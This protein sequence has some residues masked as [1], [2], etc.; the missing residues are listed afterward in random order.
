DREYAAFRKQMSALGTLD[1]DVAPRATDHIPEMQDLIV[2]LIEKGLAYVSPADPAV[3]AK[4]PTSTQDPTTAPDPAHQ[5]RPPARPG[6]SPSGGSVYFEVRKDPDFGRIF[7]EPYEAM[8][9]IA[10]ERGNFPADPLKRDPLDFVLWQA[11][12]PGEPAWDSPWGPGRPG[13]HIECSAM[14]MKYLGPTVTIH[15][16]GED[17]VFPHHAAETAQSEQATGVRPFVRHWMHAAMVYC[18]EHKMSKSLGNMVF[19]ADL[20]EWCSADAL[21]LHLLSHHYRKPWDHP[22]GA[23]LPT[24]DLAE[25]LSARLGEVEDGTDEDIDRHGAPFLEALADDF[26]TPRAIEEITRM[27]ESSDPGEQRAARALGQRILGLTFA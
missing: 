10:N 13:W 27:A 8:L 5:D 15:G 4:H 12:K 18:G 19:V 26:D 6:A 25:I 1:P 20:L 16:G 22:I 24:C 3:G 14:A 11:Q 2:R 9:M 21:R 23:D 7:R 17:L